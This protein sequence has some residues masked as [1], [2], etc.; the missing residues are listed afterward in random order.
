MSGTSADGLTVC[1]VTVRPF[2]ILHFKNYPYP[3]ALQKE[4]LRAFDLKAPALSALHFKLGKLYAKTVQK[5]LK[6][7]RMTPRQI[8]VIG[9]HGQTVYHG[10][11]DPTPSTL[12]IGEPSFLAAELGV[13]V[14]S[15]FRAKDM[16]LGGEGAPLIPFFDEYVFGQKSPKILLNVG[17]IANFSVVGKNVK[18]FGFDC[19]PGNTLL[20]LACQQF[21]KKPYDKNG[22]TAAQGAPDKKRVSALLKQAYFTRKPPKSLDK[23]AFGAEYLARY[24]SGFK[25]MADLLATLTFFT[26]AAVTQAVR[27]FVPE[28]AQKEIV[29]SG[30]GANNHT[31]L[32]YLQELNPAL[33][34]STASDYGIDPQAKEAAAFAVMAAEAMALRTNHCARATGAKRNA[35]LGK[36][37]L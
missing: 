11:K 36:I 32:A 6:E 9:S 24:F 20:D 31:L 13:P 15:D 14:V 26:A 2:K 10:P 27:D 21:L 33:K 18:T 4:L 34:I 23:N 3:P 37:T 17:G 5:F 1:A 30:G 35:V 19:G 25:R 12:Q 7:F 8:A 28:S 22:Q 29:V 16:A